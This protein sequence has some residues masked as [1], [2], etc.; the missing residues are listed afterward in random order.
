MSAHLGTAFNTTLANK[1][2]MPR[3]HTTR[4]SLM[5][6]CAIIAASVLLGDSSEY[7]VAPHSTLK[8]MSSRVFFVAAYIQVYPCPDD[9]G[10]G[11]LWKVH[12][13]LSGQF[14]LA[15][16]VADHLICRARRAIYSARSAC[17][18]LIREPGVRVP[19]ACRFGRVS[20]SPLPV[21]FTSARGARPQTVQFPLG[22]QRGA[23]SQAGGAP[24][25]YPP[26]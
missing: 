2:A 23:R 1:L 16:I 15:T 19:H 25:K 8:W 10:G 24:S 13:D 18:F 9:R 5:Y 6:I 22:V 11:A 7:R 4:L 14:F 3:P 21:Q 26:K 17:R 12:G 20:V